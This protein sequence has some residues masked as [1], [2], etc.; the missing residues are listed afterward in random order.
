MHIQWRSSRTLRIIGLCML[1]LLIFT[2]LAV[3][4]GRAL[5]AHAAG[6]FTAQYAAVIR[7][8]A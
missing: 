5:T 6:G 8:S 7:N 1:S 2:S 4:V 3:V